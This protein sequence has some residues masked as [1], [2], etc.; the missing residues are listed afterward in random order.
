MRIEALLLAALLAAAPAAA[1]WSLTV[2][3]NASL[4]YRGEGKVLPLSYANRADGLSSP[5]YR[6]E[7]A[8]PPSPGG[9]W[10]LSLWHTGV[11][12]GGEHAEERVPD[13]GGGTYQTN[14]LNVGFTNIFVT[15]R[16]PLADGPLEALVSVSV[17][18]KIFKRKD[19]VIQGK[20]AGRLD[21]VNEISAE[22][23]GFGLAGSHPLI[24]RQ[25]QDSAH[26]GSLYFRWQ[27]SAH[28]YVQIFDAKTDSSAGQIFQAESGLGLRLSGGWSVE[29][30]G[31]WHY[32]FTHAQGDRRIAF[33]GTDGAVIS[34]NRQET[35]AS[36]AYLRVEK[37]FQP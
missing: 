13:A 5:V 4:R 9:Y 23:L 3:P 7:A 34:W 26:P 8:Q 17:V 24:P 12:G 11:F 10:S 19:F 30:G 25:A 37:K 14:R 16:R 2:L 29:A 35:R 36:G 18:R 15:R 32:W 28:Q 33:P 22:G 6:L 27:A 21:D 31:L 1:D 20:S